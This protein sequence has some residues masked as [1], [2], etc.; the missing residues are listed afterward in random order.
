MTCTNM[1]RVLCTA[2]AFRSCSSLDFYN[3][4]R[5]SGLSAADAVVSRRLAAVALSAGVATQ[6]LTLTGTA[7]EVSAALANLQYHAPADSSGV[8]SIKITAV[9]AVTG[10]VATKQ[11]TVVVGSGTSNAPPYLTVPGATVKG[12]PCS[13]SPPSNRCGHILSIATLAAVEDIALHIAGL[14]VVDLDGADT[15]AAVVQVSLGVQHGILSFADQSGYSIHWL[16]G[17]GTRTV[18]M[19]GTVQRVNTALAGT[20]Y[21]PDPDY[22]GSDALNVALS[23]LGASLQNGTASTDTQ[24]IPVLVAAV[25]DAPVIFITESIAVTSSASAAVTAAGADLTTTSAAAVLHSYSVLEDE[26]LWLPS[27]TVYDA[28]ADPVSLHKNIIGDYTVN[29][30]YAAPVDTPFEV[31]VTA[32][33]GSVM[34]SSAAR[35]SFV[36]PAAVSPRHPAPYSDP[37][38][39]YSTAVG[40]ARGDAP[41]SLLWWRAVRFSGSLQDV[42]AALRALVY[43]PDA[44]YNGA[45]AVDVAV[46][47][48]S[49]GLAAAGAVMTVSVAAVN[50]A[51]VLDVTGAQYHP[52]LYTGDKLSARIVAVDPVLAVEDTPVQLNT[53]S[54]TLRDVDYS[55]WASSSSGGGSVTV[56]LTAVHGLVALDPPLALRLV[57]TAGSASL[58]GAQSVT[59]QCTLSSAQTALATL[60]SFQPE[61]HYSGSGASLQITVEDDG[62]SGDGH[63]A[64]TSLTIPFTVRAV[65]DAPVLTLPELQTGAAHAYVDEGGVVEL[66]GARLPLPAARYS[67]Q[68]DT[69]LRLWSVTLSVTADTKVVDSPLQLLSDAPIS[70]AWFTQLSPSAVLFTAESAAAGRELWRSDGTAG[71]TVL[72][73]DLYPGERGASPEYLTV[74]GGSTVYFAASGIDESWRLPYGDACGGFRQ[75]AVHPQVHFAVS[76]SATWLPAKVYDCPQH[77]HWASTAEGAAL[78]PM[79]HDA[80][81]YSGIATYYSQCGWEG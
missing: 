32:Q 31:T 11:V 38:A 47:D 66:R 64:A 54:L 75:S 59:F 18:V 67:T 78:F 71:G 39:S 68:T 61:Q 81:G 40:A 7:K 76:G 16:A 8:D 6:V 80:G 5:S 57:V 9:D 22:Y 69:A 25:P 34:L 65:N 28:D 53:L 29:S 30:S 20:V 56:T 15:P 1:L 37:G 52:L 44:N 13:T 55:E 23:D 79:V 12:D 49:S 58:Q 70:P 3:T 45:D 77:Y 72:V 43:R 60:L 14:S 50:D 21:T 73:K 17:P 46:V 36:L 4:S 63:V 48:S 24:L 26:L 74:F 10:A 51:P 41:L 62:Y 42:N 19:T 2:L 27:I 35:L 33:H